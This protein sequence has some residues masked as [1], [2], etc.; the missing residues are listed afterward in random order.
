MKLEQAT[1][2][3]TATRQI[4][5]AATA[6][7]PTPISNTQTNTPARSSRSSRTRSMHSKAVTPVSQRLSQVGLPR[8]T[9][10]LRLPPHQPV[11]P[12]LCTDNAVASDTLA[13]PSAHKELAST[14]TTVSPHLPDQT[15]KMVLINITIGYS[16]CL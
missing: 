5:T 2:N 7:T 9:L 14:R 15:R 3:R 8:P 13:P 4:P 1:S 10:P 12:S 11:E 16:Q 6:A